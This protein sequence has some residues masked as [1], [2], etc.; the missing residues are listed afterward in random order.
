MVYFLPEETVSQIFLFRTY[1]DDIV[2]RAS[3]D[4][5]SMMFQSVLK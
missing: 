5:A 1:K 3:E 2:R 4:Q